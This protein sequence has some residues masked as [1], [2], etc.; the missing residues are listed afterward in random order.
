MWETTFWFKRE[1]ILEKLKEYIDN[2]FN[3]KKHNIL[4]PLKENC[5]KVPNIPDILKE[6]NLPEDQYYDALSISIDADY[7]IHLKHQMHVL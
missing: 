5:E 7:Q 1:R 6:L 2:N 4:K 3:P